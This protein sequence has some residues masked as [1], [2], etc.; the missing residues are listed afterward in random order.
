MQGGSILFPVEYASGGIANEP[1]PDPPIGK[2]ILMVGPKQTGTP[3]AGLPAFDAC[4]T[5]YIRQ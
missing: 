4:S 3:R 5:K 1:C 2:S